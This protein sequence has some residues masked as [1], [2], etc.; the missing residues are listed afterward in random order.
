MAAISCTVKGFF[1]LFYEKNTICRAE[2]RIE[3]GDKV[4][5]TWQQTD[6]EPEITTM[7]RV[8]E[9]IMNNNNNK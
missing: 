3:R 8:T 7:R 1:N 5:G 6:L 9:L 2:G 4:V